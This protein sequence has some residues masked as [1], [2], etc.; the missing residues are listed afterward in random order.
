[1][2]MM[3]G[4]SSIGGRE[5][6]LIGGNLNGRLIFV[7]P[8]FLPLEDDVLLLMSNE[9]SVFLVESVVNVELSVLV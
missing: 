4:G 6:M 3:M 1:M 2:G 7:L 5:G 8:P 9:I